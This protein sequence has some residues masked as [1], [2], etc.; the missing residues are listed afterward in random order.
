MD[1]PNM[2]R[3]VYLYMFLLLTFAQS[4]YP[5]DKGKMRAGDNC[6]SHGEFSKAR[7]YWAEAWRADPDN[8]EH[9]LRVA[10]SFA[11]AGSFE[12]AEDILVRARDLYPKDLRLPR[13]LGLL[14][15][16]AGNDVKAEKLFLELCERAPWYPNVYYSLGTIYERRGRLDLAKQ[17]YVKELNVNCNNAEAWHRLTALNRTRLNGEFNKTA[18]FV[19]GATLALAL[20]LLLWTHYS[21][22]SESIDPLGNFNTGTL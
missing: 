1:E 18:W 12:K 2:R 22:K 13:H 3:C 4:G 6:L 16:K 11:L 5:V 9:L 10:T 8:A 7:I 21:E 19:G 20:L 14:A 17:M 15:I